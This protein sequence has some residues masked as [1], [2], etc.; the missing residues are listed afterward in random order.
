MVDECPSRFRLP[1]WGWF[2]LSTVVLVLCFA[3]LS[4]W[5]PYHREQPVILLIESCGGKVETETIGPEWSRQLVGEDRM[6]GFKVFERVTSVDLR[7]KGISDADLA[8][9]SSLRNLKKLSLSFTQVTDAGLAHVSRSANL[10]DL[11]LYGTT[12]TDQ[13]I[14]GL[15][16]ALPHCQII[17]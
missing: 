13:G 16:K 6:K 3:T 2:L 9:L 14:K 7:A 15:Q 8:H 17:H 5:W 12:V 1:H 10:R 11:A 4:V